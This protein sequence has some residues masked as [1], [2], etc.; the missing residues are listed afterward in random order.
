MKIIKCDRCRNGLE[1]I[2]DG[3]YDYCRKCNGGGYVEL[4][5]NNNTNNDENE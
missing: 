1:E 4:N 5:T 2:Y 3:V